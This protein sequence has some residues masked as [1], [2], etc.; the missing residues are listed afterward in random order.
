MNIL[1]LTESTFNGKIY[2]N[3]NNIR[4]EIAWIIASN[5]THCNI[6]EIEKIPPNLYDIAIVILPK[7]E[8]LLYNNFFHL[9]TFETSMRRIAKKVGWMQEGNITYFQD[10][11]L[12][13]QKEW[14][15]FLGKMDFLMV[16]NEIDDKY[17]K[18]HFSKPIFINQSLMLKNPETI[19]NINRNGVVIGGNMVSWYGGF[20]SYIIARIF[21]EP[22]F[23]PT[24]GRMKSEE[25]NINGLNHIPYMNWNSWIDTLTKFKY[26]IH[27][28]PT[29]A[30]GTFSLNCSCL[31]IPCIG[32]E[33]LDT[34]RLLHSRTSVG[35]RNI[36]K[37]REIAIK[38]KN[39]VD[40]YNECSL[41]TINLYSKYYTEDVWKNK[42]FDF[43]EQ[44]L[45]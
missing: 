42:F 29:F 44:I 9:S 4:T 37:A 32:Y 7:K 3:F 30:A 5:G 12:R 43:M 25:N 2:R 14:Y 13:I 8:E 39:D 41:E 10:Y 21:N 19:V 45:K 17:I 18:G 34:Q 22:I 40:F 11:S 20:D 28:M 33:E 26:A 27:L 38:L 15:E 36:S 16:H 23:S 6:N 1:W 31:G 24:M 35:L